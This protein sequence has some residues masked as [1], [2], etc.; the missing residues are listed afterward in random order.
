M[1]CLFNPSK[2]KLNPIFPLLALLGAHHIFHV[3]ELGVNN[4]WLF[5]VECIFL[6]IV[7]LL[8]V[9][10]TGDVLLVNK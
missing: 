6:Y 4:N 7:I 5:R 8:V 10:H 3:S 9:E 1:K 2:A